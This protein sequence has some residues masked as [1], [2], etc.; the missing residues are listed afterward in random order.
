VIIE[1]SKKEDIGSLVK[2]EQECFPKDPWPYSAFENDLNNEVAQ[3]WVL[4]DNEEIIGYYDIWFMFENA[5]IANIAIK[6]SYQGKKL[7]AYLLK[8]LIVRCINSNVEFLHLEVSVEN[9]VAYNLYKKFGFEQLR[10]RKAYYNGIDGI[11]MVK[12]LVGLSEKDISY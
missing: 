1:R 4:K 11:D 8:D 9:K 6:K 5:D 12:G 10:I 2:I 7:G 3:I